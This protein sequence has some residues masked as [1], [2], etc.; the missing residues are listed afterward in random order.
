MAEGILLAELHRRS[1]AVEVTSACSPEGL[2]LVPLGQNRVPL[3][4]EHRRSRQ[5]TGSVDQMTRLRPLLVKQTTYTY[6][7]TQF[8]TSSREEHA[9]VIQSPFLTLLGLAALNSP[10]TT[11]AQSSAAEARSCS[12]A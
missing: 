2:Q 9:R 5:S 11:E 12:A 8:N 4:A 1:A 10:E 7:N 3:I 6:T